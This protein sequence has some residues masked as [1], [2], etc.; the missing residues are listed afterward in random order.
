MKRNMNFEWV[1]LIRVAAALPFELVVGSS[2]GQQRCCRASAIGRIR[3]GQFNAGK[4]D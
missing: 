4:V 3:D 2:R 1:P